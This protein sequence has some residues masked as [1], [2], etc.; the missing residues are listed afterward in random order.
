MFNFSNVI[1]SKII[2]HHIGNQQ[3][4]EGVRYSKSPLQLA[5]NDEVRPLLLHYFLLPFK[6]GAFFNFQNAEDGKLNLVSHYVSK[7]FESPESFYNQSVLLAEHLYSVSN[8]PKIKSGELYLV[9]LKDCVVEGEVCD[10]LGIFKSENRE[11]FLKVYPQNDGFEIDYEAGIN[12]KKLDKGCLIFNTE[13]ESGYKISIV[14]NVKAKGEAQYWKDDFLGLKMREDNFYKTENYL[15]MCKSFVDE[16]YNSDHNVERPD[17]IDFL[18]K[19]VDFFS[20]SENFSQKEFEERVLEN[21][22][23]INAFHDYK[24]EFERKNEFESE[25]EFTVSEDAVKA[26][27][28]KFK[29]ILKLDKNFHIYIHGNRDRIIRGRDEEKGMNFYKIYFNN[30][31]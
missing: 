19:S 11:T 1:L 14:D 9:Y 22:E 21:D 6:P 17:Q 31:E 2:I 5:E 13:R 7:I 25:M 10:A 27:K 30:E 8:H 3:N 4:S 26:M 24:Q 20:D 23:V 15:A 12:I 18:N 29:S 28:R 16:I